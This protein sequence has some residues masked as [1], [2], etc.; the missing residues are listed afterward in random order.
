MKKYV[1]LSFLAIGW[2]VCSSCTR[3]SAN[4]PTTAAKA[5]EAQATAPQEASPTVPRRLTDAEYRKAQK[6][7][8]AENAK[9]DSVVSLK[10]GLQY[11][12]LR[13]GDGKIPRKSSKVCIHYEGRTT[14]GSLFDSSY[15][16]QM[17]LTMSVDDF[18]DGWQEAL[19][20][21]PV[22]SKWEIYVPHYL[23]YGKED[24]M[25]FRPYSTLIFTIE[26]LSIEK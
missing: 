14:D 17:A 7:W 4:P 10:S 19:C 15:E 26:L 2:T 6:E 16:R 5:T 11:K 21:M 24:G 25:P 18:I 13:Q 12:I 20:L 22:G 1:I 23:A 3:Q 8:L 9:K